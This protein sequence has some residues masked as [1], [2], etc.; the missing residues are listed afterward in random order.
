MLKFYLTRL[1][2]AGD[3][4][5]YLDTTVAKSLRDQVRNA[6]NEAHPDRPLS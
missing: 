3:P 2:A 1:E 6:Y 4:Q 5:E